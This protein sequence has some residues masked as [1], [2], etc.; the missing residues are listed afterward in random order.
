MTT[1]GNT[2]SSSQDDPPRLAYRIDEA[3]VALGLGKGQIER[4]VTSG[5]L[6]TFLVGRVRMVSRAALERFIAKGE[7]TGF[8]DIYENGRPPR[9]T[10][11]GGAVPGK[12][13]AAARRARLAERTSSSTLQK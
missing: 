5:H 7:R 10:R 8:I 9:I 4:A 13:S 6:R 11:E 12:A 3:T 1:R 2:P